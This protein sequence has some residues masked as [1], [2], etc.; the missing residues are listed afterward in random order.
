MTILNFLLKFIFNQVLL[1]FKKKKKQNAYL[2]M[3]GCNMK[4]VKAN[5]NNQVYRAKIHEMLSIYSDRSKK[6]Q[7]S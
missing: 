7:G 1:K 6:G 5:K 4:V 2:L 3:N